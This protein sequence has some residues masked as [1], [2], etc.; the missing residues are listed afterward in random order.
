[1]KRKTKVFVILLISMG[2]LLTII[3][4]LAI[5]YF[6]EYDRE[7]IEPD[8]E[9][10]ICDINIQNFQDRK[11]FYISPKD[12]QT[13]ST[14]IY[15]H[16]GSYMAEAT[17]DHWDFIQKLAI[18]AKATVIMPD[19]PLAPKSNYKEVYNMVE[20]LYKDIISNI[21]I[22]N[23]IVMGDS[24]GGGLALGLMEKVS[25][26]DINIPNRIVL[27]SPWLDVRLKN[28]K[29]EEVQKRDKQLNKDTLKLAGISYS[30]A[31]DNYL[32][33]PIDGNLS[34][35]KNITIFTG[36]DDILNPDVFVLQDK[37]K[38]QGIEIDIKEYEKAGHIWMIEKNTNK[39]LIENG[40]KDILETVKK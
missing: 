6:F 12:V 5:S 34:K 25:N 31:D 28:P 35:L 13:D 3:Y 39:E 22:N 2:I 16:G 8:E 18:D 29:I 7:T 11:V 19:Y 15:F 9:T 36:T 4:K 33:N 10:K 26:E 17:K 40:Y 27:I 1:M 30:N 21:D 38:Q 20:P 14:I 24:A 23:L 32:V 37:A